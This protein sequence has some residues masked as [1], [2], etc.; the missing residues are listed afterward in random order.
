MSTPI[1]LLNCGSSSIKY[2]VIDADS[3]DVVAN[4]IIQRI[5]E[6]ESTLDHSYAGQNRHD[7]HGFPNHARALAPL[8]RCRTITLVSLTSRPSRVASRR[9]TKACDVPWKP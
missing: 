5:G 8:P 6:S 7:Q 2:Q 1:L 3:E 9:E 4:G